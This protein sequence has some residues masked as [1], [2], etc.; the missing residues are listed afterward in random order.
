[1]I[2]L[3]A[4]PIREHKDWEL[5]VDLPWSDQNSICIIKRSVKQVMFSLVLWYM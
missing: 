1:M 3:V 5:V 4:L 2:F